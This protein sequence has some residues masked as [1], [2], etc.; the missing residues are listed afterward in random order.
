MTIHQVRRL[1]R[2]HEKATRHSNEYRRL[3]GDLS[4]QSKALRHLEKADRL[5]SQVRALIRDFTPHTG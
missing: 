5:Y 3:S 4:G 1:I 2:L